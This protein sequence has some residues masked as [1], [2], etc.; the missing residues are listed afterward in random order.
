MSTGLG[1]A[2]APALL[3]AMLTVGPH[4]LWPVLAGLTLIAAAGTIAIG[5]AQAS[6]TQV[7]MP[8]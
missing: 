4:V 8:A 1:I 2:V 6:R 7:Q 5:R 3:T